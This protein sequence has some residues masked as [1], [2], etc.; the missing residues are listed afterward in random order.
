MTEFVGG[1]GGSDKTEGKNS[2]WWGWLNAGTGFLE[3][4]LRPHAHQCPRDIWTMPSVTCFNSCL[5]S[6]EEVIMIFEGP[7][8]LN[9]SILFCFACETVTVYDP[10][11]LY[12]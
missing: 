12:T 2:L 8:Q 6:P 4:S 5:D 11:F 1:R 7:F 10:N 3:R 9:C